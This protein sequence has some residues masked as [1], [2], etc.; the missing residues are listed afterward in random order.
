MGSGAL[1][2][3]EERTWAAPG[4]VVGVLPGRRMDAARRVRWAGRACGPELRSRGRVWPVGE[5]SAPRGHG[6][7]DA[8]PAAR[9]SHP[10]VAAGPRGRL[11][12]RTRTAWTPGHRRHGPD[13]LRRRES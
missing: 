13:R 7:G 4:A 10:A 8:V 9:D 5:R 3:A 2:L 11:R 12:E 1:L 6:A